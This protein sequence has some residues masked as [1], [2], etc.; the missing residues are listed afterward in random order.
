[1]DKGF[2]IRLGFSFMLIALFCAAVL[3]RSSYLMLVPSKR[4][5]EALAKQFRQAPKPQPRRGLILDRNREALAVSL[6]VK[7]LYA[8]P[9]KVTAIKSLSRKL[10][11]ILGMPAEK[12]ETRLR[13]D[14]GFVWIKRY[15]TK[16][17]EAKVRDL[18]DEDRKLNLVLGFATESKRFYPN[19]EL[20]AHVI[21]F[22]GVDSHGLEGLE[23]AYE[24]ELNG[25][26]LGEDAVEGKSLVLTLDKGLQHAL[27]FELAKG[28]EAVGAKAASGIVMDAETGDIWAMA[29]YPT[30]NPNEF[31]KSKPE[32]RRNRPVTEAFEP[33]STIKLTLVSGALEAGLIRPETKF[34]CENGKMQIG[35]RWIKESSQDHEWTW[36]SVDDIIKFS[37][38]IGATKIGFKFGRDNLYK[39]YL[40]QGLATKT[41]IDLPGEASGFLAKPSA[42]SEVQFSNIS[43]GQGLSVTAIQ[44]IRSFAA[45]V[46][47]GFL[48]VPRLVSALEQPDTQHVEKTPIKMV[49]T[50]KLQTTRTIGRMM[51]RVTD[52]DGTGSKAR[53]QGFA[54]AG[55]T[56][57]AQMA[58]QGV[59]Y[60]S[61]KY[62]ASFV[63]YP[64]DVKPNLIGLITVIEPNFPNIFGGEVAAPIFQKVM[65]VALARAG[66]APNKPIDDEEIE[67]TGPPTEVKDTT[68][69]LA[70]APERP[71][72]LAIGLALDRLQ[73]FEEKE[74]GKY[75]MPSLVGK[76]ARQILDNF[77]DK[78]VRLDIQGNG[79]VVEQIPRAGEAFHRGQTVSFRLQAKIGAAR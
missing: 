79:I 25:E 69:V 43:F 9:G 1:M 74:L 28:A 56:G 62:V 47:G 5:S 72:D 31:A 53:L 27:E 12:I 52:L 75:T 15:M 16:E 51:T 32:S 78:P 58:A 71:K 26:S 18:L 17:E 34:F 23:Y 11:R 50:L 40:K 67:L 14:K 76:S 21:G 63:G 57:T 46:N 65:S 64:V 35:D 59:G 44:L 20:A 45:I 29:S 39:W 66:V 3:A 30:Y 70:A 77:Q 48:V 22:T 7:S 42:W 60:A 37:S 68:E 4:L 19:M 55:K 54:I 36:L 24:K 10:A 8:D 38:N 6:E 41:G 61:G 73:D 2:R 33:G 49:R 13:Q